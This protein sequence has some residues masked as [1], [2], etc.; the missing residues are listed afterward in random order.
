MTDLSPPI[1]TLDDAL[2]HLAEKVK[3]RTP[4]LEDEEYY[5][6]VALSI[7]ASSHAFLSH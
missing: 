4:E 5:L 7:F 2:I 1:Y 6:Y 3:A